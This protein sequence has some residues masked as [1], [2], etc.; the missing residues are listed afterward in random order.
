MDGGVMEQF[1]WNERYETKS[2]PWD[3]GEPSRE[4]GRVL[5]QGQVRPCRMLELGCG[6]GTNAVFLA[7]KGFDVT[8]FDLA[9]LA[10]EQAKARAARANVKVRFDVG[11][12]LRLPDLG[13]PFDFVFDRGVYHH[14]R[15]VDLFGFLQTLHRVTEH[16][17]LYLTLAGNANEVRPPEA[18][19][20]PPQVHGQDLCKELQPLFD[21]VQL[22]EFH[23]DGVVVEGREISPLGWS[24]L[25]RRKPT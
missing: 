12:V 19:E 23:F 15:T 8:A 1:N 5:E 11:D 2:T 3:S 25:L 10:I 14:L 20:G 24:A 13:K 7:Q 21:L 17:G 4:L 22:R 16:G 18:P 6:S 9:P